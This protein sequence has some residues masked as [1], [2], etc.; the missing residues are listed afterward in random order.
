MLLDVLLF[1]A[2]ISV[3]GAELVDVELVELVEL[4]IYRG[5]VDCGI[6]QLH[7]IYSTV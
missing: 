7:I 6:R 4:G 2:L 1:V 5:K 3:I